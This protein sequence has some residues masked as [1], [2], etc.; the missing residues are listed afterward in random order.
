MPGD[1]R[2]QRYSGPDYWEL[3][4]GGQLSPVQLMQD[5]TWDAENKANLAAIARK[6]G[7]TLEPQPTGG[8]ATEAAKQL[9]E[10]YNVSEAEIEM[11]RGWG[12]QIGTASARK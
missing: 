4:K 1:E 5:V 6:Y 12:E 11:M 9:R 8:I 2:F 3:L 7:E 10:R